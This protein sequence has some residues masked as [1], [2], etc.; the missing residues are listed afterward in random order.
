MPY[1]GDTWARVEPRLRGYAG[2]WIERSQASCRAHHDGRLSTTLFDRATACLAEGRDSLDALLEVL[3]GADAGAVEGA[4][5]AVAKLPR[6]SACVDEARLSA[7]L[8]EPIDPQARAT[9]ARE[10]ERVAR[11]RVLYTTGRHAEAQ[12]LIAAA[13]EQA[14]AL[15]EA[16]ETVLLAE[17]ELARGTLAQES[18]SAEEADAG[19]SRALELALAVGHTEVATEAA[20]R[21]LHVRGT[22]QFRLDEALVDA[23]YGGALLERSGGQT[24]LAWL[25]LNNAGTLLD[26]R[27]SDDEARALYGRALAAI[28]DEG[29]S[30]EA[31]FT[32]SNLA[33]LEAEH[34]RFDEAIASQRRALAEVERLY[35]SEHPMRATLLYILANT[36]SNAGSVDEATRVVGEALRVEEAVRGEDNPVLNPELT[37]SAKLAN[38]RRRYAE[39]EAF[40]RRALTNEATKNFFSVGLRHAHGDALIG[41]GRV[42]EGL[43]SHREAVEIA[44]E[45]FADQVSRQAWAN[46]GLAVALLEA[47]EQVSG[48]GDS[49]ALVDEARARAREALDLREANPESSAVELAAALA[50]LARVELARGDR[51]AAA[52]LLA[53]ARETLSGAVPDSSPLFAQ[54]WLMTAELAE[55]EGDGPAARRAYGDAV[56]TLRARRDEDDPDLARAR[57]GLARARAAVE[58]GS[59]G[60]EEAHAALAVY[61]ALGPAYAAEG[62]E[63]RRWMGEKNFERRDPFAQR[64]D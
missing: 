6:L 26:T 55:L 53:R 58:G 52:S 8:P 64:P 18:W 40:G 2:E 57:F 27:G 61:E 9:M 54:L 32:R 3:E 4:I 37:L 23:S 38:R 56:V 11:A 47:S 42:D 20:A 22:M 36:L 19:L 28:A 16:G 35:G 49:G 13:L 51:E 44:R 15:S 45:V 5:D 43:T 50:C 41:L 34:H 60:A 21:R 1:A 62:A 30:I 7:A 31:V 46:Q 59:A 24:P 10:R 12:T 25:Y 29:D 33:Q 14:E 39:A 17:V 63:L 48:A